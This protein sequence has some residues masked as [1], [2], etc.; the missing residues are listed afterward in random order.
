MHSSTQSFNESGPGFKI[1]QKAEESHIIHSSYRGLLSSGI[2]RSAYSPNP[3]L[4]PDAYVYPIFLNSDV[5]LD[6]N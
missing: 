3:N 6:S 4:C 2:W 5:Y 1:A